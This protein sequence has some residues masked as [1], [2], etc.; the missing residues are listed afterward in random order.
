MLH[1]DEGRSPDIVLIVADDLGFSDIGCYG[2]EIDTP[3]LDGLGRAGTRFSQ[4]YCSPRCSP[5]RASL[6][7]GLH[8]HQVG[9]GILTGDERPHGYPGD[10]D[11]NCA[12]LPER[13]RD[14][15]YGTYLS[16]KWHLSAE[17]DSPQSSWPTRRGFE[18]FF[19]TLHGAGS[20]YEPVSLMDGEDPVDVSALPDDFYYTDA[21]ADRGATFVT[22]HVRERGDDPFFLYLAFT[23]P[24]WPL[25]AD[26][27]DIARYDGRYA[28][29]WDQLRR[30]RSERLEEEGILDGHAR[31]SERD[32]HVPSWHDAPDQEWQAR[33]MQTYAAQV[34]RMDAAIGRV[35]EA[36]DAQGRLENTLIVFLTDNGGC[37]EEVPVGQDTRFTRLPFV[38]ATTRSGQEVRFGN[39]SEINP[40]PPDTFTS[41]GREWANLSN[42]PFRE[43]KHWVHEGGI[44]TPLI[45][46]WPNGI[47]G[48]QLCRAPGQLVDLTTTLLDVA[49]AGRTP[50]SG[51][52]QTEGRS[53]LPE[54]RGSDTPPRV[55]FWEHEG[56]AGLRWGRWKAVR[57]HGQ[58]WELYDLDEDRTE[59]NNLASA[60]PRLLSLMS[61]VYEDRAARYGVIPRDQVLAGYEG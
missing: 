33:R 13:L 30:R 37:A 55:L 51:S 48:H 31:L 15:G 41:Y 43:Y 25:H 46:H 1:A 7:T 38:S 17:V 45:V 35:V 9:V 14:A 5:S 8:P 32:S 57:K 12:T 44:A 61:G 59:L 3:V 22:E 2:G 42:T 4:F 54:L 24:H 27:D 40:G 11:A 60:E 50:G 10:L 52:P 26:E 56:N 53:L 21:I 28:E 23:A 18:R 36:L 49:G 58:P 29:G 34:T 6:L 39:S 20:F 16:G 47:D 19:G